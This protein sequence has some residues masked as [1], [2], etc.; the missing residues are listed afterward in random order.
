MA[1]TKKQRLTKNQALW[2]KELS[3]LK[4]RAKEWEKKFHA[5]FEAFPPRPEKVAKIDI[6]RLKSIKWKNFEEQEK[7]QMQK[8]YQWRYDEQDEQ[9]AR[10]AFENE[11]E[12]NDEP[13]DSREQIDAWIEEKIYD[14]CYSTDVENETPGIANL[15][16]GLLNSARTRMGDDAFYNF[17]EQHAGELNTAATNA[18]SGS[19]GRNRSE[20][21][22]SYTGMSRDQQNEI[23][24]FAQILN[25]GHDLTTE[26]S[27]TLHTEGYVN[28]DYD[29]WL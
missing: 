21:Y 5:K 20:R 15:L 16:E 8:E 28:F 29:E 1:K 18:R 17:L 6:E 26:Q 3:L 19:P 27:T 14:I 23:D 22:G 9:E 13:V 2:E 4:R 25:L 10:E 7:A 11:T 12:I 24:K